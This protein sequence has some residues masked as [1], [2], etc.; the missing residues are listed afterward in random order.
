MHRDLS[1]TT[2]VISGQSGASAARWSFCSV[3]SA[4]GELLLS[5]SVAIS[6]LHFTSSVTATFLST[7]TKVLYKEVTDV[8]NFCVYTA[9]QRQLT[10]RV[11]IVRHSASLPPMKPLKHG[12]CLVIALRYVGLYRETDISRSEDYS[13]H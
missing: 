11:A 5:A 1:P 7:R 12:H 6:L 8:L 10:A 3:I 9:G 4:I 13:I 2:P